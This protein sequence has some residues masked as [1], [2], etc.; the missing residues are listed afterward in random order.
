M[1]RDERWDLPESRSAACAETVLRRSSTSRTGRADAAASAAA[2]S[3]ASAVEAVSSPRMLSGRPTRISTAE[4]SSASAT[5]RATDS[6]VAR[7]GLDRRREQPV[8]I[9][10]GD[11][12]ARLAD[13]DAEPHAAPEPAH[14][15][16]AHA[17]TAASAAGSAAASA[18][19]PC[20]TSSRPPPPPPR[21]AGRGLREHAGLGAGSRERRRSSRRSRRGVRRPRRRAR[22][23][24]A[25]APRRSRTCSASLRTS[26]P[27]AAAPSDSATT[28]SAP[29]AVA[30]S[31]S[32]GSAVAERLRLERRDLLL[33]GLQARGEL[34]DARG[35]LIAR[36]LQ[37][38]GE[39]RDERA[40]GGERAERVEPDERLDAAVGRADRRLADEVDETDLGARR[41][42]RAARRARATTGRRCRPCARCRR[43]SRRTAPSR[44]G[45]RLVEREHAR[46]DLEVVA[47]RVVGDLLD[48]G[49][50]R[51]R[52]RLAP[53]E[54]EAHVAG[55]VE[56]SGLRRG[57]AERVAERRV[58]E[59][60][61]GVR[62]ARRAA[63]RGIHDR[64]RG[65]PDADL[66][67]R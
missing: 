3:R 21:I 11:A 16:R 4:C 37:R 35:Q 58:H 30:V 67:R 32:A 23:R 54:V 52:Q 9:A 40:L 57:L 7:H 34:G 6:V 33:G 55:A 28:R 18:P 36:R 43:T 65:L 63:V 66:A 2:N 15:P 29:T 53:R 42:V 26:S 10:P 1:L 41:D 64:R 61:R 22:R 39:L 14:A 17:S 27:D 24:P 12:D 59:V 46:R 25:S 60:R 19:P 51:V 50:R 62:L 47:D 5:M 8:R 49:L 38:R 45:L 48:L 44:R 13:V 31:A 20:A 56:R